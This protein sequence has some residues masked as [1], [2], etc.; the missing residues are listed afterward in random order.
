MICNVI[1]IHVRR[2]C[3]Y[4]WGKRL[5]D[6]AGVTRKRQCALF[7]L[8]HALTREGGA[9][10]GMSADGL[11]VLARQAVAMTLLSLLN[12]SR[13]S[14]VCEGWCMVTQHG[15]AA[16]WQCVGSR[17][18]ARSGQKQHSAS[19]LPVFCNH[20]WEGKEKRRDIQGQEVWRACCRLLPCR[21]VL[22]VFW[23]VCATD[24]Q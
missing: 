14:C 15:A 22:C 1:H 18:Q 20:A 16:V 19:H 23:D 12:L 8:L 9:G 24:L 6:K 11:A 13:N 17:G 21:G 7:F 2:A 4:G 5:E 10:C 3:A